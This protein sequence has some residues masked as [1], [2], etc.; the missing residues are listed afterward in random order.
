LVVQKR[1]RAG[2]PLP[3]R[4]AEQRRIKGE[5]DRKRSEAAKA[6]PCTKTETGKT[7]FAESQVAGQSDPRA[8]KDRHLGREI[9][10]ATAGVSQTT[11]KRGK[12]L[13]GKRPDLAEKVRQGEI[14]PAQATR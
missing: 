13:K 6:Q 4:Q 5:A 7:V 9:Q 1:G 14:K 3:S 2:G 12:T 8:D 10:A 11:I